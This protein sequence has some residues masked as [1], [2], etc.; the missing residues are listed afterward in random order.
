MNGDGA[1]RLGH[2]AVD[3]AGLRDQRAVAL[4]QPDDPRFTAARRESPAPQPLQQ[5]RAEGVE[6]LDARHVDVDAV[7]LRTT[8]DD[9]LDQALELERPLSGP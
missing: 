1:A 6:T 5:P 7:A 9:A 2:D 8:S 3:L 4:G